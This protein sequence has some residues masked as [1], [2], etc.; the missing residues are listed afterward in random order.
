MGMWQ[1][2][3]ENTAGLPDVESCSATGALGYWSPSQPV[4]LS[5]CLRLSDTLLPLLGQIC[6]TRDPALS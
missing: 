6:M 2:G 4:L 5:L 1:G 3:G